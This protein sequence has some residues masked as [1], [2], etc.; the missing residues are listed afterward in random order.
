[1]PKDT[2]P[3]IL[4]ARRIF[5]DIDG[6]LHQQDIFL[7]FIK[8]A[9]KDHLGKVILLLPVVLV[10]ALLYLLHKNGNAGVRII[11][12]ALFFKK[13]DTD[14]YIKA[15]C[16]QLAPKLHR[17]DDV[18]AVLHRHIQA[19][20]DVFLISG[21]PQMFIKHIYGELLA[22]DNVHL[23]ATTLCITRHSLYLQKRCIH[24]HKLTLLDE[25]FGKPLYFDEGYSDS[26]LDM[27]VL[28]RCANKFFVGKDGKLTAI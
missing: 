5:F 2:T 14:G 9:L 13:P 25:Q 12:Y 8:Y 18:F 20:N 15:F 19:G 21:T 22:H 10:G 23:I 24:V 28:D 3:K 7:E 16:H 4:M 1:M 6:T 11:L 27:P 17:F 26:V